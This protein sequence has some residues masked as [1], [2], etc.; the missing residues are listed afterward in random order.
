MQCIHYFLL[1]LFLFGGLPFFLKK[2]RLINEMEEDGRYSVLRNDKDV[3]NLSFINDNKKKN[4][5][6]NNNQERQESLMVEDE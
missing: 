4:N 3:R 6:I 5:S 2:A 1:Y